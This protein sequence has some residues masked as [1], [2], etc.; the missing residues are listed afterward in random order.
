MNNQDILNSS[1]S[2]LLLNNHSSDINSPNLSEDAINYL[3]NNICNNTDN[4]ALESV[5][6]NSNQSPIMLSQS[7]NS[8]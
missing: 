8:H 2:D 4:Q 1:L 3:F 7:N 6:L 5:G